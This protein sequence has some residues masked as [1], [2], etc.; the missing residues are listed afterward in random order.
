MKGKRE[1]IKDILVMKFTVPFHQ[2]KEGFLVADI[3]VSLEV[4]MNLQLFRSL[5]CSD[6]FRVY[7]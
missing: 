1:D 6:V 5:Y 3:P 2:I 7:Q 4:I